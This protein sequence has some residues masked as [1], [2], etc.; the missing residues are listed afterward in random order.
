LGWKVRIPIY[1]EWGIVETESPLKKAWGYR[2]YPGKVKGE[3]LFA[4]CLRKKESSGGLSNYKNNGQQKLAAK[5]MD[6]VRL[7]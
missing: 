3:G 5:E 4:A 7:Y 6:I 2:F 1:K